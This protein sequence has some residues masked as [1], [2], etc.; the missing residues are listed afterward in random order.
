M[1]SSEQVKQQTHQMDHVNVEFSC[2]S[3]L[4]ISNNNGTSKN[5]LNTGIYISYAS[6]ASNPNL[7][8]IHSF[9]V[10]N[11]FSLIITY[12]YVI[13]INIFSEPIQPHSRANT[14]TNNIEYFLL[15]QCCY[16]SAAIHI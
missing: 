2:M 15:Y 8:L 11:Q 7:A 1:Q 4:F 9:I 13:S 14:K 16:F 5:L 12:E 3:N 6:K 10:F